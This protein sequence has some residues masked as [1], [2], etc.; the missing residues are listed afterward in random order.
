MKKVPA[1]FW[2]NEPVGEEYCSNWLRLSYLPIVRILEFCFIRISTE[3]NVKYSL[4]VLTFVI[5]FF[6]KKPQKIAKPEHSNMPFLF[7]S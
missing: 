3:L 4:L 6:S 5:Q 1:R 2:F 7:S